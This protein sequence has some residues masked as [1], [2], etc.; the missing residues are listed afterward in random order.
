[1][2]VLNKDTLKNKKYLIF[3]TTYRGLEY[4]K[5]WSNEVRKLPDVQLVIIDSGTQEA[6]GDFTDF[7]IYQC[8][9]N[10]GCS[11]CWNLA[12][13]IGFNLYGVDK[14]IIGQ[15]DAIFNENIIEHI[16]EETN[17]DTLAGA[18]NRGFE[19]SFFGL[20]KNLYNTV[21]MFD[22]NFIYA[23]CEDNE[24]THRMKLFNKKVKG[25]QYSA[26]MNISLNSSTVV[27]PIRQYNATYLHAKWGQSYEYT[28]PFNDTNHK[29]S[30]CGIYSGLIDV[31]G[32]ITT[33]P[34]L[35][36]YQTLQNM[37]K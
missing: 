24:Y 27:A 8:S 32:E 13:N 4:F 11:G 34:S 19:F 14:I 3:V 35:V 5:T 29:P 25:L 15:D 1:M 9:Q 31:Y 18:Y 2:L 37:E 7:P 20:T 10:I 26:D 16:W 23:G 12:A 22:E 30:E 28:H 17:D 21:G 33:F 6:V 36:E